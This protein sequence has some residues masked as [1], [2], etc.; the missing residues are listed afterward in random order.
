MKGD[1]QRSTP[2]IESRMIDAAV[3][4]RLQNFPD[5]LG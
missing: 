5:L 4:D 2:N 3:N 1:G